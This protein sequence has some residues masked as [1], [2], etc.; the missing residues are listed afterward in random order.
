MSTVK[1]PLQYLWT[2]YLDDGTIIEQPEDDH[3]SKHD[4]SLEHN[5]SAFRD[6]QD[7]LDAGVR[8]D[9]F[10][11]FGDGVHHTVNLVDGTFTIDGTKLSLVEDDAEREL[12][13]YR[14]IDMELDL[15]HG[16][17]EPKLYSYNFGYKYRDEK[18]RVQKKIITLYG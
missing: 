9:L 5:P 11:L 8:V 7:K 4:D 1:E 10:V 12:I 16:F 18:G 13:Y 3:Y 2:A 14:D 17:K 15:E 6:I